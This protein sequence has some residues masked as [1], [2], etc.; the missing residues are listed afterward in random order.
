MIFVIDTQKLIACTLGNILRQHGFD[1][2]VFFDIPA[3]LTKAATCV[4]HLVLT[5]VEMAQIKG[6]D[7]TI[8][9]SR[10]HPRCEIFCSCNRPMPHEPAF[11]TGPQK[12]WRLIHKP[13]RPDNLIRLID[14]ALMPSSRRSIASSEGL[15]HTF[16]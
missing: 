5:T 8:T 11:R 1:T 9:I 13:I 16:A 2:E 10:L 15:R 7:L 6:K 14:S 3:A 12:Y 4:P